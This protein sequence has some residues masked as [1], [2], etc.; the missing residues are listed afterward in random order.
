VKAAGNHPNDPAMGKA[1]Q[2]PDVVS[3]RPRFSKVIRHRR[4]KSTNYGSKPTIFGAASAKSV[5][6]VG[7]AFLPHGK[8][9]GWLAA[10]PGGTDSRSIIHNGFWTATR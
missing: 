3:R 10:G 2:P 4:I 8:I 1:A 5:D 9:S 7:L 6:R